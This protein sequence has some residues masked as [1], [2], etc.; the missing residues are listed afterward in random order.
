MAASLRTVFTIRSQCSSRAALVSLPACQRLVSSAQPSV[1]HDGNSSP[2]IPLAVP[3]SQTRSLTTR[4]QTPRQLSLF[5]TSRVCYAAD[6]QDQGPDPNKAKLGKSTISPLIHDASPPL[7]CLTSLNVRG[8]SADFVNG[9]FSALKTLQ[10]RLPTLLQ[11][12]LPQDILAPNISLR[13]FPTTHPHLPVVSGRV[14]YSAALWTSPIAWNRVPV[15]GNVKLDIL[16]ER[17]MSEPLYFMPRREGAMPEQLVVRWC[18]KRR[19][20]GK[21]DKP[22]RFPRSLWNPQ[23]V[24]P[25]KAFYGLFI[26]D[27]DSQGRILNHTIEQTYEG[28]HWEKGMGAKFVDL[29]DWL[30]GG[31]KNP[32]KSPVPMFNNLKKRRG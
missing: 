21:D 28:T 20:A 19:E 17:M 18:E 24:E 8:Q 29:T 31:M 32:G 7:F 16:A 26:F 5:D 13:L 6:G 4:G 10:E 22:T 30:L 12:P 11:Y 3:P 25:K 9:Q 1:H 2:P 14:A 23:G 27:F 15:I